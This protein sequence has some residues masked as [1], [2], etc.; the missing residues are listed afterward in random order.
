MR[1]VD[2]G[3]VVTGFLS[4]IAVAWPTEAEACGGTFCDGGG[5]NPMSMPVD[6]TGENIFFV[7]ADGEVEA[8]IQIQYDATT[9]A[10]QFAW[11]VPVMATPTFEVGSQQMFVALGNGTV[12]SYGWVGQNEFCG[13]D[14]GF[15]GDGFD[16]CEGTGADSAGA[17]ET[18]GGGG[19][20]GGT[21]G[22]GTEVVL[23]DTVGAFEAVVLQSTTAADLMQWLGDNGYYADPNAEPILQQYI[24]EGAQ[25]AAFRLG[26]SAGVGEIHPVVIRYPGDEPCI[27][28]R[29]TRIAAQ[30]DMDIRAFFLGDARVVPTNYRHVELNPAK[31][32]W[33]GLG[34]NYK[35]VVTMAVDSPMADGRAFVTEYAGPSAIVDPTGLFDAAWNADAFLGLEPVMVP[36]VLRDQGLMTICDDSV[37]AFPHP[38]MRGLMLSFLPPPE[39]VT[40]GAFWGDLAGYVDEID[41]EAWDA[42]AFSAAVQERIVAPGAHAAELLATYP[43][44]TRLY[45]TL[46]PA[47]MTED[48]L[49]HANVELPEVDNTS[50]IATL[51]Q[52]CFGRPEMQQIGVGSAVSLDASGVW[53]DILPEEMPWALRIETVPPAGAPMVLV[54]NTA[55]ID[56]LVT[57]W[58]NQVALAPKAACDGGADS[59][60]DDSSGSDGSAGAGGA[61]DA[62]TSGCG[63]RTD[64]R[65]DSTAALALSVLA[66]GVGLRS[67]R[68]RRRSA[69]PRR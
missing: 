68:R 54:D 23:S 11:I 21:S 67:S 38:L 8:H 61:A 35:G 50:R 69:D 56:Q 59:F 22:G 9:E 5:G 6:Q 49:F 25:F 7:V 3:V 66:F 39:G 32:D 47:E 43:T 41:L 28:I 30:D 13:G 31:L 44:L 64:G 52:P 2:T 45:T 34:A 20:D 63:C 15:G 26:Q 60:G 46:S 51:F 14:D 16:S 40:E 27:P 24:D 10:A 18:G 12:P 57:Q 19:D 17:G 37:C 55:L 4:M 65:Q 42:A 53:P 1:T 33:L 58:N 62:Q 48:P 29:L 36:D